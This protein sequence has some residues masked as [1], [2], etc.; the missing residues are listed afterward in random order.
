M[1]R[2]E[3]KM[4]QKYNVYVKLG[5]TQLYLYRNGEDD[6]QVGVRI[7]SNI[8]DSSKEYFQLAEEEIKENYPEAWQFAEKVNIKRYRLRIINRHIVRTRKD[9][10][11]LNK[12]TVETPDGDLAIEYRLDTCGEVEGYQTAFTE[13]ELEFMDETG[14][15]R[16]PV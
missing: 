5:D 9:A 13:D 14:F 8:Y 16:E 6:I 7:A 15:E 10:I 11:Y 2:E 3:N 4:E 1:G 12:V